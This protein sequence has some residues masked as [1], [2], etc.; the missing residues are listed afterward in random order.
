[1]EIYHIIKIPFFNWPVEHL[2]IFNDSVFMNWFRYRNKATLYTP[3]D[4]HLCS[5]S[6]C[7]CKTRI[8]FGLVPVQVRSL[9]L[10]NHGGSLSLNWKVA[11]DR[12]LKVPKFQNSCGCTLVPHKELLR[13]PSSIINEFSYCTLVKHFIVYMKFDMVMELMSK[14]ITENVNY[15][16]KSIT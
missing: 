11:I 1:M 10:S 14:I 4:H 9:K 13:L 7:V 12:K 16:L 6:Y 2:W 3:P 5:S 8:G 15:T